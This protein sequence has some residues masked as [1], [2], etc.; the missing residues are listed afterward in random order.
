MHHR[1]QALVAKLQSSCS[2]AIVSESAAAS[3]KFS[4]A[5]QAQANNEE[6]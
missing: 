4:N 3:E 5:G 2:A 6:R 1:R